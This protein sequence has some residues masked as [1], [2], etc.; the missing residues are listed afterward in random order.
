MERAH[1]RSVAASSIAAPPIF[2]T[3][4][5]ANPPALPTDT[6]DSCSARPVLLRLSADCQHRKPAPAAGPPPPGKNQDRSSSCA[7]KIAVA[8]ASEWQIPAPNVCPNKNHAGRIPLPPASS[9]GSIARR[10]ST[11]FRAESA[12][13]EE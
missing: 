13:D 5:T 9:P 11:E 3:I 1:L 7:E 8:A 2:T 10:W 6:S 4:V 12:A